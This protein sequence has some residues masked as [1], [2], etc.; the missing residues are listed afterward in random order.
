MTDSELQQKDS[1]A[2]IYERRKPIWFSVRCNSGIKAEKHQL[3]SRVQARIL[4]LGVMAARMHL[5]SYQ[6][7]FSCSFQLLKLR[8][9]SVTAQICFFEISGKKLPQ[10]NRKES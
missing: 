4:S 6:D 5:I 9:F 3:F 7:P 1:Y 8:V 10:N 2:T